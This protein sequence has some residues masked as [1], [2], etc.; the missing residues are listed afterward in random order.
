MFS[1]EVRKYVWVILLI[2]ILADYSKADNNVEEQH[3]K[4]ALRMVGHELL[5]QTGDST[6]RVLP[7]VKVNDRYR[8]QFENELSFEPDLLSGTVFK[9]VKEGQ[10]AN[11]FIVEVQKCE[12]Q[13][14]VYSFEK[15]RLEE[16]NMVPCKSRP[17]SK[18][19]YE[20]Y[21]TIVEESI[22]SIIAEDDSDVINRKNA[23]PFVF[24]LLLTGVIAFVKRKKRKVKPNSDWITFGEYQFDKKGMKLICKG[25][26]EELSG[27]EADLLELLYEN[28]N[29]T[30][31]REQ[32]LN[33]VWGDEGD[34]IGR[35]LDVFISKLRKKLEADPNL[36]IV[37][38]RGVGYRFVINSREE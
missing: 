20:V 28:E 11:S 23:I 7:I 8:I 18:D 35:T 12:N 1:G 3:I 30:L 14:V 34:Y 5:L 21:F 16:D 36:K 31:E 24:V 38:I 15:R 4:V 19:C 2:C 10:I 26:R 37:N 27:K 29:K 6:S 9:V 22:I 25:K 33:V 17:L 13:E 32:I